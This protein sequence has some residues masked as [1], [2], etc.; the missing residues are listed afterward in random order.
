MGTQSVN[1]IIYVGNFSVPYPSLQQQRQYAT[2][3]ADLSS[4]GFKTM[5][6][7]NL[8]VDE[9]GNLRYTD[10]HELLI[11][12]GVL[13]KGFAFL[14]ELLARMTSGGTIDKV[15]FSLGGWGSEGDYVHCAQLMSRYGTGPENPI[16]RNFAAL[17]AMG[18]SG[19]DFDL[20]PDSGLFN[21]HQYAYY[22]PVVVQLTNIL[23]KLDMTVTYCPYTCPQ[24]W[25]SCLAASFAQQQEDPVQPVAWMNLQCYEGGASNTHSQWVA[26]L[27]QPQP[28]GPLGIEDAAAFVVPG[29]GVPGVRPQGA[30]GLQATFSDP[31]QM[32]PGISG[33]FIFAY[34]GVLANQQD[35]AC[36]PN[37]ATA[38]YASAIVEG[39]GALEAT[40]RSR[41]PEVP[42]EHQ[43]PGSSRA[44][45]VPSFPERRLGPALLHPRL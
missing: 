36:G 37:N 38:D 25:L 14:P 34:T 21:F 18:V 26:L 2:W 45:A 10:N 3:A 42:L 19:I 40:A 23:S 1:P 15:M 17:T 16:V 12:D 28:M 39:I 5:I 11:A 44:H 31:S 9:Y 7:W 29:Y 32:A 41:E 13:Q 4:S 27:N 35:G 22:V 30:S 24:F 6:L 33:G 43:L 20:E 8:H